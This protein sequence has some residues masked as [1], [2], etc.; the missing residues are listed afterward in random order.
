MQKTR[1]LIFVMLSLII[2]SCGIFKTAQQTEN[3]QVTKEGAEINNEPTDIVN[4]H[5]EEARQYYVDALKSKKSGDAVEAFSNFEAALSIVN[6]LSYFPDIDQNEAYIELQSAIVDDYKAYVDLFDELPENI[7]VSALEEWLSKKLPDLADNMY[8]E[9]ETK[10]SS[11]IVV[12]EFPLQIN[13]YVEKYIEYFTGTGRKHINR[14]LGRSGKF[15]PMMAKIFQEEKVPQQLLY[16]SMI[17]S[18][19]NPTARSWAKA[20]GLWQFIRETGERYGLDVNFYYDERMDPEKATRAA[21]QHLRD[22]YYSLGDWYLALAAYNCGEGNVTRAI[23]RAGATDY[24]SLMPYLPKETR[25]YVPQYIAVTL[26]A[27]R[28]EM[29]GFT[30]LV[31]ENPIEFKTHPI[32]EAIDLA[33]LSKCAG[34]SVESLRELNPELTQNC[35]PPG[36]PGGYLLKIP[37]KSY[38]AFATNLKNIPDD[39]K[40]NFV[41]HEVKKGETLNSIANKY[42]VNKNRLAKLNNVSTKTKLYQGIN[43][44]I[45]IQTISE[46]D[47]VIN[48]DNMPAEDEIFTSSVKVAPYEVKLDNVDSTDYF[49]IY[50]KMN[51]GDSLII[52]EGKE[53][54][55]YTVKKD[56]ALTDIAQL[57]QVRIADLR[58]WNNISYTTS[59]KVGQTLNIYVP[60]DKK[61]HF[62][63]LDSLKASKIS[64]NLVQNGNW[65]RHKI[66]SGETLANIADK[67]NVKVTQIKK[68]N[69]LRGDKLIV[70]NNLKIF[71][72]NSGDEEVNRNIKITQTT[73]KYKVKRGESLS[74]IADKFDVTI[75][76]IR[77]WNNLRSN[78]IAAGQILNI[79]NSDA[80]TSLGDNNSKKLVNA[81]SY[82]IKK[83]DTIEE[84]AQK[85]NVSVEDIKKWNNL[86]TDKINAGET[87]SLLPN[88]KKVKD[89]SIEKI[90]NSASSYVV[91]KGDSIGKIAAK[92]NVSIKDIQN[93]N[94]LT[95]TKIS[96]GQELV[97]SGNTVKSDSSKSKNKKTTKVTT[98]THTVKSGESLWIIAKKYSVSV[99]DLKSVN[100][101]KSEKVSIG[102]KIQIPN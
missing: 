47:L 92:F 50:S 84:I 15:F 53:V 64:E 83:G 73:T 23:N 78:K 51:D 5:L 85:N 34:L 94:N 75:A 21:A 79:K 97:V 11:T 3:Q 76:Q 10:V 33:V 99:N 2:S 61:E 56:D 63:K 101:L 30:E 91:K 55:T 100:N 81:N 58:N 98:N 38:D 13:P 68:W 87:L 36:V 1:L 42:N 66:K 45:P 96:V 35:T 70:G 31:Y 65:L 14:W 28:P 26:I 60:A 67:Y 20:V 8:L 102:Q 4:E 77:S 19:L 25:N 57:F 7:S 86:T 37:S 27:S 12:G 48:T 44:K 39:L 71:L 18:G 17:E 88:N 22:L 93:W 41:L 52:P 80:L 40:Q 24:W 90:T 59:I 74:T 9:T 82:T 46:S 49:A 95:G 29:Y 32:N 6:K 72:G 54:V 69:S 43:L 16:L 89:K 62:A